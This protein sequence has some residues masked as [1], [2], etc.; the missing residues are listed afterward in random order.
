MKEIV[1]FVAAL[2]VVGV[3]IHYAC[4]F[5]VEKALANSAD[6]TASFKMERRKV[7]IPTIDYNWETKWQGDV[8]LVGGQSAATPGPSL[9]GRRGDGAAGN[10]SLRAKRSRR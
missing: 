6:A 2:A 10:G 1:T 9:T 7:E 5:V 8:G 3:G 4:Q